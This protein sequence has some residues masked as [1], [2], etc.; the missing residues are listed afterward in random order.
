MIAYFLRALRMHLAAGRTLYVLTVAGVALGVASVVCIQ[1][2]N[3]NS[4]SAFSGG[5]RAVSGDADFSVVGFTSTFDETVLPQV[6][7]DPDVAAAWPLYRVD[8]RL[9]GSDD[10]FLEIIGFD[11]FAPAQVPITRLG[12]SEADIPTDAEAARNPERREGG[13]SGDLLRVPGWIAIAPQLAAEHRWT[14]GD[15]LVVAS[16]STR[17]TLRIGALVDFQKYAPFASRRLVLMDIAQAQSLFGRVGQIHS[18]EVQLIEDADRLAAQRRLGDALGPG[19]QVLTQA[20]R[21]EN[22]AG[23]LEA[24]RLNLTALSLISVFVGMFLI[25]ASVQASLVRRRAEFGLLRSLGATQR[26]VV[27]LILAEALLTGVLGTAAGLPLG[28]WAATRNVELVS[29]TL[30]NIYLLQ[31]IERLQIPGIIYILGTCVGIGGALAGAVLPALEMSRRDTRALLVAFSVHERTS[32]AA[33]PLALAGL[34]LGVAALVAY[35]GFL[36]EARPGGFVLG[37]AL[38]V[39]LPLLAPWIVRA[40]TARIP[41]RGWGWGLAMKNLAVR[42]QTTAVSVAALAV[43]V[44]MLLGITILIASFRQTLETWVET[45]IRADIYVTTASWARAGSEATLA[46]DVVARLAARPEVRAIETLRQIDVYTGDRRIQLG[47]LSMALSDEEYGLPLRSG[48]SATALARLRAG[49][50]ALVSEPL[51]RKAKLAVGDT[52]RLR[53]PRG[54]VAFEIVGVSYDYSSEA[55]AALISLP[56]LDRHFGPA[57]VN[58]AALFLTP[59]TDVERAVDR[60]K[61]DLDDVPL[62]VRSN[63]GIR[64]EILRIFDQTFAITRILQ[65]MALLI[66]VSGVALTLLVLARERVGE[67]ALYRALG[68]L[69]SQIFRI[70]VGEGISLGLLGLGLGT[71]GGIALA[72]ILI[73][74]INPAFFGWT[75]HPRWPW[76]A[77]VQQSAI[78]LGACALA[79]IYPAMRATRVDAGEL[80]RDDL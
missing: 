78:I 43:A 46:D 12:R 15:S 39:A 31:E 45:S 61:R 8:V 80:S 4:L 7:G 24:F 38:L 74:V 56:A 59:G 57:P 73:Y 21:E 42:L 51:S 34:G 54:E 22:A 52:L 20:Q 10:E 72:L 16:G 66:A 9:E 79:S 69:R 27:A 47:G 70:F 3:R 63:L 75:I 37:A 23:L 2:L 71:L 19:L 58:N 17:A 48:N 68:A 29:A 18:I 14:V 55:G 50:G 33:G 65:A 1:V 35:V 32:R 62:D 11:V 60:I 49:D 5:V 44:S 36:R 64:T 67:L 53:A 28:Y 40:F 41:A 26:Q 30:T 13:P 77:V 6:L 25:Y 76:A